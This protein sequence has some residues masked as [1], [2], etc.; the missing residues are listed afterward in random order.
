V[1]DRHP[2]VLNPPPQEAAVRMTDA[3][4][5]LGQEY[6]PENEELL[7]QQVSAMS[8]A[9][10]ERKP[11]PPPAAINIRKVM[12]ILR[13]NSSLKPISPMN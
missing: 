6:P 12:G 4:L 11:H 5:A 13:A 1:D 7:I 9:A 2:S 10:M 3:A 8:R